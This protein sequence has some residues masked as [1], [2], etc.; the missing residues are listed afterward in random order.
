[1][2]NGK[3]RTK[4]ANQVSKQK[5]NGESGR[6]GHLHREEST[7][8]LEMS[9]G[10]VKHK[11]AEAAQEVF[12]GAW[13]NID[14]PEYSQDLASVSVRLPFGGWA[15]IGY[16]FDDQKFAGY[17]EDETPISEKD[18]EKLLESVYP[19][20]DSYT[21]RFQTSRN[22]S[23]EERSHISKLV[24]ACWVLSGRSEGCSWPEQAGTDNSFTI[25]A[26]STK[27][28]G[29]PPAKVVSYLGQYMAEGTPPRPSKGNT[30]WA[31]AFPDPDLK[32]EIYFNSP[33]S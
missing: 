8:T 9:G 19:I 21:M 32:V 7:E 12:G 10:S 20:S 27:S 11:F 6:F 4:L 16:G 18:C 25:Y 29:Y 2:K 5:A 15:R 23:E 33:V 14:E 17:F 26:D 28:S 3:N 31:E 30:R 1:M 24:G 13:N 22:I